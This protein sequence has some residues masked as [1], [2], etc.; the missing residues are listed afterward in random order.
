MDIELRF[1]FGTRSGTFSAQFYSEESQNEISS[2]ESYQE[3]LM[4][5]DGHF[6]IKLS[7]KMVKL[8]NARNIN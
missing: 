6:S 1:S 8:S 5:G 4:P 2:S 7:I 3:M